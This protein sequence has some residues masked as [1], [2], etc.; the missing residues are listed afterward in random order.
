MRVV[1][2]GAGIAGLATAFALRRE[3]ARRADPLDLTI[4]EAAPRTGGRIRTTDEDGYRIEWAANGI[5]GVGGSAWRLAEALG[6]AGERV[7]ARPDAARRYIVHRGRLHLLPMNPAALLRFGALSWSGRIRTAA[8]PFFAKRVAREESVHDFA[9]RHI[10]VEA[11]EVLIGSAVRGIF[12]GDARR[13]SL[14][15]AFPS[16][17]TMEREHG[18]L[19]FAMM[20]GGKRGAPAGRTLWSL[21][22]GLQSL[23]DALTAALGSAVRVNT[24][25]LSLEWRE[26]G[27][28]ALRLASGEVIVADQVVLATSARA[29]AALLRGVDTEIARQLGTI[30]TAGV[31]VAALAFRPDAFR[32]PPDGYG[33]LVAPG[34]EIEVLGALFESNLF[35]GRAPEDR[36]LVRVMMGGTSRPDL[37][38]QSDA[39]LV[40]LAMRALD[41]THGLVSGPVR[42]WVIRQEAAIPQYAVGHFGLLGE[43]EQR[44]AGLPGLFLTGNSYR[45]VSV[46]ALVENAERLGA[47]VAL[48]GA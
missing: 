29:T 6:L 22:R 33:Y 37:L 30:E 36:I 7:L 19:L 35:P 45:G 38:T 11:A 27:G 48:R 43:L 9:A 39:E 34:E 14:D 21:E 10:G 25:V 13:L 46:G 44:L 4:L 8:E 3:A 31:A 41:K 42:T 5:Q 12:A 40:A 16:M 17:R 28:C 47:R 23:V 15:A 32:K 26:W 20:R 2:V 24:P 1:I 18:S